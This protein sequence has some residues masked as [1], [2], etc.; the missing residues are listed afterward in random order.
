MSRSSTRLRLAAALAAT[1]AVVSCLLPATA[2][3]AAGAPRAPVRVLIVGDSV[4]QGAAGDW[5]WRYWLWRHLTGSGV[6]VDFVGPNDGLCCADDQALPGNQD[7]R[8]PSFDT[9]HAA[10]WGMAYWA[11]DH[12]IQDLVTDYHPDVVVDLLGFNDLFWLGDGPWVAD[13]ARQ[14][15]TDAQS[16]DPDVDVVLGQIPQ[17]W[18]RADGGANVY[19]QQLYDIASDRSDAR[20]RVVVAKAE[21]DFVEGTDTYD[22]A[23]PSGKGE[24]KIAAE[25]ADALAGLGIGRTYPRPIAPP[26][27]AALSAT[28]EGG[29]APLTWTV[30][31][32]STGEF[33]WVRN[34]TAGDDWARLA[35]PVNGTGFGNGGLEDFST[36]QFKVETDGPAY[37]AGLFS[38]V[39]TVR[40]TPFAPM[41][42]IRLTPGEGALSA[43]WARVAGATGYQVAWRAGGDS[44]PAGTQVVGGTSVTLGD[45]RP[46]TTYTVSVAPLLGDRD[47]LP[48]TAT[49]TTSPLSLRIPG[50]VHA[51]SGD[52]AIDVTWPAA[53]G[54][55]GYRVAWS[56]SPSGP[57]RVATTAAAG[58][59]L[60]GLVPGRRYQITVTAY[61]GTRHRLRLERDR[62][63]ERDPAGRSR[64][65][66]PGSSKVPGSPGRGSRGATRYEV[67]ARSP[68]H[69]W[70]RLSLHPL[71]RV[72]RESTARRA[73][74]APGPVLERLFR[75]LTHPRPVTS[76]MTWVPVAST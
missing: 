26:P 56:P 63:R 2:A 39:V 31:K 19:N 61:D 71:H 29:A 7:Y 17:T 40:P 58:L 34:V 16:A 21:T 28:V 57:T 44:A 43:S 59:P 69:A 70:Q 30:P 35:W 37:V 6:P 33:V 18:V 55:T 52:R 41:G 25:I 54:A 12:P 15:V 46:S 74:R 45:L 75:I 4:T 36:Y 76:S 20:S 49:A 47:D 3:T 67:Q 5:T 73:P 64:A 8:D 62:C 53:L 1:A 66:R 27:G 65:C 11:M 13:E 50:R 48:A 14:F 24:V 10:R 42:R 38:N 23:H 60:T 51:R 32:D 9:D 22:P 68:G 72:L